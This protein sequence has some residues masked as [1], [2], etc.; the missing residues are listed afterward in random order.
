M[1]TTRLLCR[2]SPW[3]ALP[4][5]TTIFLLFRMFASDNALGITRC[6]CSAACG[7]LNLPAWHSG[8]RQDPSNHAVANAFPPPGTHH[9]CSHASHGATS[10]CLPG[11]PR[12]PSAL[13]ADL[14]LLFSTARVSTCTPA[15][16]PQL[17]LSSPAPLESRC[18]GS[19]TLGC[20][21]THSPLLFMTR[22]NVQGSGAA[23][24]CMAV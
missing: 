20:T 12:N 15:G 21:T 14:A 13:P 1:P 10:H 22:V 8:S 11:G 19:W 6:H 23:P 7:C 18:M 4:P 5:F 16:D 17:L 2:S 9:G 3:P 24:I